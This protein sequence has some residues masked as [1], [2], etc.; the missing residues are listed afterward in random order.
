MVSDLYEFFTNLFSV[1]SFRLDTGTNHEWDINRN[2]ASYV[3]AL[4]KW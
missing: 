4:H 3:I 2:H 1:Y